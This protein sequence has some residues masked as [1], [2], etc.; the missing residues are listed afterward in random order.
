MKKLICV[1]SLLVLAA[2]SQKNNQISDSK[3]ANIMGGQEADATF[4]KKNGIVALLTFAKSSPEQEEYETS[5]CTGTMVSRRLILT[6][7]H[8]LAF[9]GAEAMAAVFTTSLQAD[10][11]PKVIDIVNV[12]VH[13]NLN[14]T[15]HWNIEF[16]K[17]PSQNDLLLVKLAEDAPADFQIARL[18]NATTPKL[19]RGNKVVVAGYGVTD[20]IVNLVGKDPITG[21]ITITPRPEYLGEGVLRF[22]EDME[23]L[24]LNFDKTEFIMSDN[25]GTKGSCH[26]DS[27]G[28]SFAQQTDGS[29]VLVGITNRGTSPDGNCN[30]EG[31]YANLIEQM[32]WV[33]GAMARLVVAKP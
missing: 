8:C 23:V 25:N 9:P 19:Q 15:D 28:P 4:Q 27:G 10:G 12:E 17:A 11:E 32:I 3:A 16:A 22:V 20:P 21:E 26:G 7:A 1:L 31:I 24:G 29:S 18:P 13:P 14:F 30:T 2:C 6:A 33:R 5:I